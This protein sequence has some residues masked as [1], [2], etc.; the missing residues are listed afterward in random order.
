MSYTLAFH[1]WTHEIECWLSGKLAGKDQAGLT[2]T[3][4]QW[5]GKGEQSWIQGCMRAL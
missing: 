3:H 1:Q 5:W 4:T 2:S